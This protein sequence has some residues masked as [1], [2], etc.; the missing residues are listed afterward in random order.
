MAGAKNILIINAGLNG[1]TGNTAALLRV[2]ERAL[3]P[4]VQTHITLAAGS[5]YTEVQPAV[6]AA[7][8]F[9][10]GTGTHWDSWSHLLQRFLEEATVDEGT[11]AFLGKPAAVFVTM[12]SVGGKAVLSRSQG[13]LNTL[14]CVIPPMGGLVYARVNQ[15]ALRSRDGA[16]DDIWRMEDVQVVCHNLLTTLSGARD[17]QSWDTDRTR[18]NELWLTE[19]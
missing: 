9:V 7:D 1:E 2:A 13:V 18:F 8:A 4:H 5:R 15:L 19:M 6:H 12:H 11:S 10:I 14:G 17:Y 16:L 3:A